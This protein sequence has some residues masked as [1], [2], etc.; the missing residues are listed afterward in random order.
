MLWLRVVVCSAYE[1][2]K[3]KSLIVF[4]H[5]LQNCWHR[6]LWN[7]TSL[8]WQMRLYIWTRCVKIAKFCTY[9]DHRLE[10]DFIPSTPKFCNHP[11]MTRVNIYIFTFSLKCTFRMGAEIQHMTMMMAMTAMVLAITTMMV[12]NNDGDDKTTM[13]MTITTMTIKMMIIAPKKE[14]FTTSSPRRRPKNMKVSRK[15][16]LALMAQYRCKMPRLPM[17]EGAYS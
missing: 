5:N 3:Q 10:I 7:L 8:M 2:C 16:V 15:T 17:S 1:L 13:M 9:P 6:K 12:A 4:H 11:F 14:N